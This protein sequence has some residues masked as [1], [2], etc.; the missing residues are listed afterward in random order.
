MQALSDSGL[1]LSANASFSKKTLNSIQEFAEPSVTI[2]LER[3]QAA[4]ADLRSEAAYLGRPA[5]AA[6][7]RLLSARL[8]ERSASKA[9]LDEL[10]IAALGV[11]R[12]LTE[13]GQDLAVLLE[14]NQI[15]DQLRAQVSPHANERDWDQLNQPF[16]SGTDESSD[17]ASPTPTAGEHVDQ[18]IYDNEAISGLEKC[19]A[20]ESWLV[21]Q[22]AAAAEDLAVAQS[23]IR[24]ASRLLAILQG[25]HFFRNVDRVCLVGK[26]ASSNQLVVVDSAISPNLRDAGA[27]NLMTSGYSCFVSPNGSLSAMKPGTLRLFSD[28]KAVL[29]AFAK[30]GK[31]VQR[32]IAFIAESGLR[33]GICLAIGRGETVQGYLFM[34]SMQSQFFKNVMEEYGPLMSLFSLLGTIGLDAAGFHATNLENKKRACDQDQTDLTK[35]SIA[36]QAA[37]FQEAFESYLNKQMASEVK[38]EL[39]APEHASFLYVP[40]VIVPILADAMF[41]VGQVGIGALGTR[42]LSIRLQDQQV[43]FSFDVD[44]NVQVS[45][46]WIAS[47]VNLVADRL[48]GLPV[49][50]SCQGNSVELRVTYEPV[51]QTGQP[52]LYSVAN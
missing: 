8:V 1:A 52:T 28:S 20:E 40:A 35:C 18:N 24:P 48:A 43:V 10:E 16:E 14:A 39:D 15:I 37:E 30:S 7:S 42:P 34:N 3:L 19:G 26:V 17:Q 29:N 22:V 27:R 36:F 41:A 31:P 9:N 51:L 5:A 50:F 11:L 47:R 25:H 2:Y 6:L 49:Q 32:S 46:E 4:L 12:K 44:L 13:G 45:S 33:S 23:L 21:A 38:V